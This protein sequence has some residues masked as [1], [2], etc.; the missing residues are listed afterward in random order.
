MALFD[1]PVGGSATNLKSG[2]PAYQDA[3]VSNAERQLKPRYQQAL[4]RTRQSFSDSGQLDG[5]L[6]KQAQLGLQENYL[7]QVGD[8]A[9]G[10]ATKGADVAEENRR[11][12]ERRNWQ[13][14]DRNKEI[15]RLNNMADRQ[16]SDANRNMWANLIG[17]AASAVGGGVGGLLAKY[18]AN[19]GK[20]PDGIP[21]PPEEDPYASQDM[22]LPE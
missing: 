10:A 6:D 14:E 17:G 12:Q 11:T 16:S 2:D 4:N 19:R 7:G 22:P 8:I 18:L 13:V 5:G 9:T 15:E 3:I 1:A 21:E 20:N